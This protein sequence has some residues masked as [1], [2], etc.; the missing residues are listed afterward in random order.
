MSA[1]LPPELVRRLR[2][3]DIPHA[4]GFS[5]VSWFCPE[6]KAFFVYV[7]GKLTR[8]THE[9]ETQV[10]FYADAISRCQVIAATGADVDMTEV[11]QLVL[12]VPG[13]RLQILW[14]AVPGETYD[15]LLKR[16]DGAQH[17][18]NGMLC[19]DCTTDQIE[20]GTWKV[21]V[22]G[23]IVGK[24][25]IDT[26]KVAGLPSVVKN[27]S[28]GVTRTDRLRLQW[29]SLE[30]EFRVYWSQI[31]AEEP[32]DNGMSVRENHALLKLGPGVWWVAVEAVNEVGTS[33]PKGFLV[34]LDRGEVLRPNTP[35]YLTVV[36]ALPDRIVVQA[37]YSRRN[38]GGKGHWC[39]LY[40]ADQKLLG[41]AKLPNSPLCRVSFSVDPKKVPP[42]KGLEAWCTVSTRK[43]AV[44]E[45]VGPIRL[46]RAPRG[47]GRRSVEVV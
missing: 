18:Y 33:M 2:I 28:Y 26:V 42:R 47:A 25:F 5:Q 22:T 4:R 41:K 20:N 31:D 46:K 45:A 11:E 14:N 12:T 1:V 6:G 29:E 38:E 43:G 30:E 27:M 37:V 9:S 8:K 44:G 24:V 23:E 34:E 15:V 3:S 7:D 10:P 36:K 39:T 17:Q 16:S 40:D 21:T 19:G 35:V 13:K 32:T